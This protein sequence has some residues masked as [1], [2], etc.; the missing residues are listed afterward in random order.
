MIKYPDE[1]AISLIN[2]FINSINFTKPRQ[3][4]KSTLVANAI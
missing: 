1:R 3:N 2:N 4:I